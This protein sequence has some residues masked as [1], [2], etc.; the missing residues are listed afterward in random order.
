M[1]TRHSLVFLRLYT[2]L[3]LSCCI[4]VAW[5]IQPQILCPVEP[6][7]LSLS[8]IKNHCIRWVRENPLWT[9][10]IAGVALGSWYLYSYMTQKKLEQKELEQ[11]ELEQKELEQKEL[12][13]KELER[14]EL[15]RKELERKELERKELERKEL[16]RKE[17]EL[18]KKELERE[19][20][21]LGLALEKTETERSFDDQILTAAKK[22]RISEYQDIS[23]EEASTLK[24]LNICMEESFSRLALQG[25]AP[26]NWQRR[27]EKFKDRISLVKPAFKEYVQLVEKYGAYTEQNK[28]ALLTSASI[29]AGYYTLFGSEV[30]LTALGLKPVTILEKVA[31]QEEDRFESTSPLKNEIILNALILLR[32]KMFKALNEKYPN[33][34]IQQEEFKCDEKHKAKCNMLPYSCNDPLFPTTWILKY[35]KL[36]SRFNEKVFQK[37]SLQEQQKVTGL[38]DENTNKNFESIRNQLYEHY[39]TKRKGEPNTS[40]LILGL[41]PN[42]YTDLTT[43]QESPLGAYHKKRPG[44]AD[45]LK[46]LLPHYAPFY[47]AVFIPG[48]NSV[49]ARS[50]YI[51]LYEKALAY[52]WI[53]LAGLKHYIYQLG[54]A[55]GPEQS[56]NS[57]P[58]WDNAR[59]RKIT[60]NQGDEKFIK[61]PLAKAIYVLEL[62]ANQK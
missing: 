16:E 62:A 19:K 44:M 24:Q 29:E 47:K 15:E 6:Q 59:Y 36:K 40:A 46:V 27:W 13:R 52:A 22:L 39:Q 61:D 26:E 33:E 43:D 53:S 8:G 17:L 38:I 48:I 54:L 51:E 4:N 57:N 23:E 56:C 42:G 35:E 50:P 25:K 2:I 37:V 45:R 58:T 20:K 34:F 41:F 12:E 7:G 21:E 14:K 32:Q 10:T 30:V 18:E 5:P 31:H 55:I 9:L 28:K 49:V 60:Q 11:K 1:H 3:V